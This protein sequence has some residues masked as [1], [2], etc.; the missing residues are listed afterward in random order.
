MS[1]S[2]KLS[3]LQP[4]VLHRLVTM[5]RHP[6][7]HYTDVKI[8]S[9]LAIYVLRKQTSGHKKFWSASDLVSILGDA[10]TQTATGTRIHCILTYLLEGL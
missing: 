1:K 3:L 9:G 7:S 2:A 4:D 8:S 6:E 5:A 10:C